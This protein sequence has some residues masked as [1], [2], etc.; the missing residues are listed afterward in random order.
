MS[1]PKPAVKG[2]ADFKKLHDPDTVIVNKIQAAFAA[3]LKEGKEQWDYEEDFRQ[4]ASLGQSQ[5]R[6]YRERFAAHIVIAPAIKGKSQR[7]I[8]VADPKVAKMLRGE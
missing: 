2:I 3:M 8:W 1:K 5:I 6:D 4:R 7:N